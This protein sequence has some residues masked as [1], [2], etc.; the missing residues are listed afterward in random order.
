MEIKDMP[1]LYTPFIRDF[2]SGKSNVTPVINPIYRWVFDPKQVIAVDKLDGTNCSVIIEDGNITHIFNR[3]N[4]VKLFV[5]G[6]FQFIEGIYTAIENGYINLN[7]HIGTNQVF[8]ELIGPKLQGNPY[9]LTKHAWVPFDYLKEKY[10]YKFWNSALEELHKVT[11]EP[12]DT[13]LFDFTDKIFR[14]LW[15]LYKR[16]KKVEGKIEDINKDTLFTGLA[17]EGIVFY[18]RNAD[19]NETIIGDDGVHYRT[20][21]CKL[22]RDCFAWWRGKIHNY[23][24]SDT[25]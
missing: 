1:K 18:K 5:T 9:K 12:S 15:S 20:N 6:Q 3:T 11:P 4:R 10:Y 23:K 22:R 8:G 7:K 19:I 24:E 13:L 17:A 16:A 21:I 2:S 14:S 25:I